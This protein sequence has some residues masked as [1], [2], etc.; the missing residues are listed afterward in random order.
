[1][2]RTHKRKLGARRYGNSYTQA[3]LEEA[4]RCIKAGK[5]TLRKASTKFKIPTGTLSH[6]VNA[7]H[8]KKAG[9]PLVFNNE[10]EVSFIKHIE[11]VA[12]WAFPFYFMNMRV[13]AQTY[14]NSKGRTVVQFSN[15]LPS[16]D[17]ANS[18]LKRHQA[19]LAKRTCQD[20]ERSRASVS[21]GEVKAYVT[22]LEKTIQDAD[23]LPTHI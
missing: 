12:E 6:K 22:N 2:A 10:E 14:L 16:T 13:L 3:S 18:F 23:C 19:V 9:R 5:M 20:I 1:M 4:V 17:W 8:P 15:N 11:A 7:K 21:A